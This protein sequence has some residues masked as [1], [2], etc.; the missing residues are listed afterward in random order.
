MKLER[1]VAPSAL[2]TTADARDHLRVPHSSD[3]TKI[4]QLVQQATDYI[5][6][7]FGSGLAIGEQAWE[8]H[9]DDFP[10]AIRI[11]IYPVK[12]I[13]SITYV[14]QDGATQ[15]LTDFDAD[16][17]GNPA[18]ITPLS[19]ES[20]PQTKDQFNA[21][22]VTFVA[23]FETIPQDLLGAIYLLVGHWYENREAV[24]VGNIVTQ[25]PLAAE[26]ILSKYA[27]RGFA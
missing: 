3:D 4:D 11:P 2:I 6:G 10:S 8:L 9:L 24:N 16:T 14:D 1:T 15:A 12:S 23:G 7:P 22:T 19:G 26:R 18:Y 13:D 21:V 5:E 20:F 27:V 25:M 17:K